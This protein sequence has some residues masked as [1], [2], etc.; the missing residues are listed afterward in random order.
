MPTDDDLDSDW[1][2]LRGDV[3]KVSLILNDIPSLLTTAKAQT[4]YGMSRKHRAASLEDW[5]RFVDDGVEMFQTHLRATAKTLDPAGLLEVVLSVQNIPA[6]ELKGFIRALPRT[7]LDR[8]IQ[9]DLAGHA[10]GIH[11][12]LALETLVRDNLETDYRLLAL[13]SGGI[14]VEVLPRTGAQVAAP[15][16]RVLRWRLDEQF[17]TT[18]TPSDVGLTGEE[19]DADDP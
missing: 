3:P 4:A 7:L 6:D 11:A 10:K 14:E 15:R 2:I 5:K 18:T 12:L 13:P 16:D 19:P 1:H 17:S 8:I 9:S